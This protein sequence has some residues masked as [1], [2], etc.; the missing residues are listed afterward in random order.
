MLIRLDGGND[1]RIMAGS[2]KSI[3]VVRRYTGLLSST[4]E[5]SSIM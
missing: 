3:W 4:E 1:V 5:P 2:C